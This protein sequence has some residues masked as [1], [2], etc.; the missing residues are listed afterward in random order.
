MPST[1]FPAPG[2]TN[3][4][5][6]LEPFAGF[7]GPIS[8]SGGTLNNLLVLS[9]DMTTLTVVGQQA[10][11]TP[12]TYSWVP[13]AGITSISAVVVG[14]GGGG[15]ANGSGGSAWNGS[16]GGGGGLAYANSIP[17]SSGTTYTVQVGAGGTA[18]NDG[19]IS[20][21]NSS[22]YLYANGGKKGV[23]GSTSNAVG[24]TTLT[25]TGAGSWVV[26]FGVTAVNVAVVGGGGG[27]GYFYGSGGGG[28]A[29]SYANNIPVTPN[30]TISYNVGSGGAVGLAGTT[31]WFNSSS[32]I[33]ANGGQPGIYG[34]GPNNATGQT[35]ITTAGAGS[36]AA[37]TGVT[38][39]NVV[40]LG[41]GGGGGGGNGGGGGGGALTYAN[42]VPVTPGTTYSYNVGSGGAVD[43]AGTTTWF[44]TSSYLYAGGGSAGASGADAVGESYAFGGGGSSGAPAGIGGGGF[45][46]P[47]A[48]TNSGL[49]YYTF[50]WVAPPGVTSVNVVCIGGGAGG[51]S[52]NGISVGGGGGGGGGLG[53]KNNIPVVPGTTYTVQVGSGGT[54]GG[55][56]GGD[57]WFINST[58]VKGG[59]GSSGNNGGSGSN[60][61][62][63]GSFVGDG[64]GTGY[65]GGHATGSLPGGGGGAGGYANISNGGIGGAGGQSAPCNQGNGGAGGGG[66]AVATGGGRTTG[67]S[68]GGNGIYGALDGGKFT[69]PQ[70]E[71]I[72]VTGASS[73]SSGGGGGG[74]ATGNGVAGGGSSTSGST[75]AAG[76]VAGYYGG[77]GGGQL[78]GGSSVAAANGAQGAMRIVWGSGR[79]FSASGSVVFATVVNGATLGTGGGG[80]AA[81]YGAN[82]GAGGSAASVAHAGGTGGTG[83]GSISVTTFTGGAGGGSAS[84]ASAYSAATSPGNGAGAGGSG[85]VSGFGGGGVGVSGQTSVD[86]T[87]SA[88]TAGSATTSGG[89]A[90]SASNGGSG[91]SSGTTTSGGT[92]GG[93]G[94]GTY[95]GGTGAIRI[96]WGTSRSFPSTNTID[97]STSAYNPTLNSGGGGGGAAGYAANGGAGGGASTVTYAGGTGGTGGGSVSGVVTYT[98]GAGG[99]SYAGDI[100]YNAAT[101]PGGG[102]GAGGAGG[103]VPYGGGGLGVLGQTTVNSTGQTTAAGT[104]TISGVSAVSAYNGGSGGIDGSTTSGGI[105]G[106]GGPGG[107]TGGAGGN[108]AI[109]IIW[110]TAYPRS[111]PS[112]STA[113]LTT[114]YSGYGGGG[115]GGAAGYANNGGVGSGVAS[116]TYSGG[117]GGTAG[118]SVAGVVAYSGGV[119]GAS[120]TGSTGGYTGATAPASAG[121]G[122]SGGVGAYGGGG[123]GNQVQSSTDS[124]G[125]ATSAGTNTNIGGT[126]SA[127]STGGSGGFSSLSSVG[128]YYGGG[129]GGASG[130]FAGSGGSGSVRLVW[131]T[132][133]AVV[134][135]YPTLSADLTGTVSVTWNGSGLT[136]T[137]DAYGV[138]TITSTT[139]SQYLYQQATVLPSTAYTFSFY[140]KPGTATDATYGVYDATNGNNIVAPTSYYNTMSRTST[141]T[142]FGTSATNT[143]TLAA[144][145]LD[146]YSASFGGTNFVYNSAVDARATGDFTLE[147]WFFFTGVGGQN[148]ILNIGNETTGRI[149]IYQTPT[150][151][152]LWYNIYGGS[153]VSLT[154]T[155][156]VNNTWNH[157]AIVRSGTSLTTY[158]NGVGGT[159]LTLSGTLGNAT[160]FYVMGDGNISASGAGLI[161]NMRLVLGSALY[162]ANFTPARSNLA[163]INGTKFLLF[164]GSTATKDDSNNNYTLSNFGSTVG[165]LYVPGPG[166]LYRSIPGTSGIPSN[167][168]VTGITNTTLTLSA[169]LTATIG[170]SVVFRDTA[171][172]R[173][174]STFT[175][176]ATCTSVRVY[177]LWTISSGFGTNYLMGI[178]LEQGSNATA[179]QITVNS[180]SAAQGIVPYSTTASIYTGKL[181]SAETVRADSSIRSVG[182]VSSRAALRL[183]P[184]SK[185][186]FGLTLG[187]SVAKLNS[188]P[189]NRYTWSIPDSVL[190]TNTN[191]LSDFPVTFYNKQV[192]VGNASA[193]NLTIYTASAANNNDGTATLRIPALTSNAITTNPN[194]SSTELV[195]ITDSV[196]GNQ[197]IATNFSTTVVPSTAGQQLYTAILSSGSLGTVVAPSPV[198]TSNGYGYG[199]TFVPPTGVTSISVVAVGGGGM[200]NP[201][202]NYTG[203]G[204]GG[205]AWVNNIPVVPGNS[206]TVVVGAGG[207]S[208]WNGGVSYFNNTSTVAGYGGASGTGTGFVAGG[209][210]TASISYGTYGGGS[211]GN[212]GTFT[213]VGGPYESG[214]G[215]AGGYAGSGGNGGGS[216]GSSTGTAATAGATNSGAGGGGGA[217]YDPSNA[218]SAA[219]GGGGGVGLLGKGTTGTAGANRQNGTGSGGGD[220]GV[221]GSGGANGTNGTNAVGGLGGSY[222]GGGGGSA[223]GQGIGSY[224][225]VRIIWPGSRDISNPAAGQSADVTA[226]TQYFLTTTV[227]LSTIISSLNLSSIYTAQLWDAQLAPSSRVKSTIAPTNARENLYYSNITNKRGNS[228]VPT[229]TWAN[230]RPDDA[231]VFDPSNLTKQI[232]KL[233]NPRPDDA[234]VFDPN[235]LT[236]LPISRYR[237]ANPRPDDATVFD[238]SNL[239]KQ[240]EKL[241][242]PDRRGTLYTPG[243]LGIFQLGDRYRLGLLPN[244][245]SFFTAS[246]YKYSS[247]QP[248]TS[249]GIPY[250]LS[251]FDSAFWN[252]NFQVNIGTSNPAKTNLFYIKSVSTIGNNV[253]LSFITSRNPIAGDFLGGEAVKLSDSTSGFSTVAGIIPLGASDITAL[254]LTANQIVLTPG[255]GV[256]TVPDNCYSIGVVCIGG[257]GSGYSIDNQGNGVGGGGGGGGLGW[258]N[259]TVAPGQVFTY[260]VGK[261]GGNSTAPFLIN[262]SYDGGDTNFGGVVYGRGGKGGG[263]YTGGAGG[264]YTG[265]GGGNGGPGGGG[266]S[267]ADT[268]GSGGG[269]AGG[270][271]GTGG[272][273]ASAG[274]SNGTT[275]YIAATGGTGGAGGGGGASTGIGFTT[276]GGA[277]GGG[278]GATGSGIGGSGIAG[279]SGDGS[280]LNTSVKQG[281]GG[282]GG[283][284]GASKNTVDSSQAGDLGQNGGNY[285]GGG[286]GGAVGSTTYEGAGEGGSGAIRI[287]WGIGR[288]YPNTLATDQSFTTPIGLNNETITIPSSFISNFASLNFNA[289]A[290]TSNWTLTAWAPSVQTSNQ[291]VIGSNS[292][293][294]SLPRVNLMFA[295]IAPGIRSARTL[296][297]ADSI[298]SNTLQSYNMS[299]QLEVIKN[300]T[301]NDAIVFDPNNLQKQLEVIKNPTATETRFFN[302]FGYKQYKITGNQAPGIPSLR[303]YYLPT[304]SSTK[305]PLSVKGGANLLSSS[306]RL[307]NIDPIYWYN[308]NTVNV[309]QSDTRIGRNTYYVSSSTDNG[310]NTTLTMTSYLAP[311]PPYQDYGFN[312]GGGY[313]EIIDANGNSVLAPV[314]SST[315][316]LSTSSVS[317][318]SVTVSPGTTTWTAPAGV[319]TVSIL[320][321]GA[322]GGGGTGGG[323]GGGGALAYAN[324]VPVVP[325][326]VYNI[327]V[328]AGGALNTD[329]TDTWFNNSSYLFAG[330]GKKGTSSTDLPVQGQT[331]ITATGTGSWVAPTGVRSISLV[332]IGAGGGGGASGNSGGGGG[333]ALTYAN[334]IPVVPGTTY[335]YQIG[336]G[337][338]AGSSGTATWFNTSSYFFAGGGSVGSI[339]TDAPVQGQA[340]ITATGLSSWVAPTG[341]S[342]INVVVLGGGGGGG[343][344]GSGSGGGGGGLAY[345]NNIPVTPGTTYSVQVGTGGAIGA[346]GGISWFNSS[347]YLYANGGSAGVLSTAAPVQGQTTITTTGTGSWVAPTGVNAISVV[348]IGAGGGGG[349]GGNGSGGGGGGLTYANNIPVVPG[350]T[351]NY[352]IGT[353]GAVDTGGTAT[354][355]NTS[356]YL[357]A[358]GGSAGSASSFAA[359]QGQATFTSLGFNAWT[360]PAGV[361][362]ISVV[363]LGGGGGGGKGGSGG[364]GGGL[365]YA[366]NVPVT[367]G[368]SYQI[369]VGA[370]GYG[371]APGQVATSGSSS[372][373]YFDYPTNSNYITATGGS[374][375]TDSSYI[376]VQGQ[377]T[378]TTTGTGSWVAPANVSS[379]SVLFFGGGGGG[380]VGGGGGGGGG[381]AYANNIPVSPGTTYS[382]RVGSGGAANANGTSS[383]FN[384]SSYLFAGGGLA[385]TQNLTNYAAQGQALAVYPNTT[386][387]TGMTYVSPGVFNWVAPQGVTSVSVVS[388]GGGGGGGLGGGSAGGGGGGALTYA[389]SVPVTPGT[390]YT[391]NVGAGGAAGSSGTSTWFNSSSYLYANGGGAGTYS[392]AKPVIDQVT[393]TTVG[394]T[395]WTVPDGVTSISIVLLGGGGGGGSGNGGG[396]GGGGLAYANNIPV[397]PGMSID[398]TVGDAGIADTNGGTSSIVFHD[399]TGGTI[400]ATGGT[401]G[402]VGTAS[403]GIG[404]AIFTVTGVYPAVLPN[405]TYHDSWTVPAGVTSVSALVIGAGGRGGS[406]G[407]Y[408]HGGGGGGGLVWGNNISVTPG[409]TMAVAAGRGGNY[410]GFGGET[411]VAS[412]TSYFNSVPIT[413][414]S[415][416]VSCYLWAYAGTDGLGGTSTYGSYIHGGGG[417]AAGYSANGGAGSS[418]SGGTISGAGGQGGSSGGSC[419]SGGFSGGRGGDSGAYITGV[420][421]TSTAAGNPGGGAGAGGAATR[422]SWTGGGVGIYGPSGYNING[423]P[424][425][426]WPGGETL[427][428]LVGG[429]TNGGSGGY[430]GTKSAN[431]IGNA[432]YRD[433]NGQFGAGAGGGGTNYGGGVVRIIWGPG[434][435]FPSTLVDSNLAD[436][437]VYYPSGGGGGAAG[438]S[439][440]GGNGGS[441]TA[442][443][444]FAGGT[445]GAG[446]TGVVRGITLVSRSG[447]NGGASY[448]GNSAF[449]AATLGSGGAGAGGSG[450]LNSVGGGGIAYTGQ[451]SLNSTGQTTVAGTATAI[452]ANAAIVNNG[453]SGGNNG[454]VGQGGSFGSGGSGS[455][456]Y[457]GPGFVRIIYSN[458]YNKARSY[459][460]TLTAD[461][462]NTAVGTPFGAGGGGGAAGYAANGGTGGSATATGGI[463]YSGGTGGTG[464]G[465][466]SVTTFTGGTGGAGYSTYS[467]FSAGTNPGGGAG[468]GG[469]GGRGA[470]G[471]GG[472]GVTNQSSLNS[473]GSTTAGGAA[474][475]YATG[476]VGI[477]ATANNGGSG[478]TNG[479]TST[480]GGNGAGGPAGGAG[481]AGALRIIWSNTQTRAYPNTLAVDQAVATGYGTY[482]VGG[483]G[484]AAGY[485][486]NG[487]A[488]GSA[489]N[490]A[491]YPGGLGGV[492]GGSVAGVSGYT[493]GLGGAA[494]SGYSAFTAP[495]IPTYTGDTTFL[496]GQTMTYSFSNADPY[497]AYRNY[498]GSGGSGASGADVTVTFKGVGLT[499]YH[500][501]TATG[502]TGGAGGG[503]SISNSNGY[504]FGVNGGYGGSGGSSTG[505]AGGSLGG[506]IGPDGGTSYPVGARPT[507]VNGLLTAVQN[508]GVTLTTFAVGGVNQSDGTFAGAGGGSG[509]SLSYTA[510]PGSGGR[511]AVSGRLPARR[512]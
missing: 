188:L 407:I 144:P 404:E 485:A 61:G 458:V 186:A 258:K 183:V 139:N 316:G 168:A 495:S 234:Y 413:T 306:Y 79:S 20:W 281:G 207:G 439:G 377:T 193:K 175:T 95:G 136:A 467:A 74:G 152:A 459:P 172:T 414:T 173:I 434:R 118:G 251:D 443:A 463:A 219:G 363:L 163:A 181:K 202:S 191:K 127:S 42:S 247:S 291:V 81:G 99:G 509:G 305:V 308:N 436:S 14:G 420:M 341:V 449:S 391:V 367:P 93:G 148:T 94:P 462:D 279:T 89:T 332:G 452:N 466:I 395:N 220:G 66:G 174:I 185:Y 12:G 22:T 254:T 415:Q 56:A 197:I 464:G 270:Y 311:A 437:P 21:F 382:Y 359:T 114:L 88:T 312:V 264:T 419:R 35:T 90:T 130:S 228:I 50:N 486:A 85:G 384:T 141:I 235:K 77:G 54:G 31:S 164:K 39:I 480:G 225:A 368:Q 243:K 158:V 43:T 375:G 57:T 474:V 208:S 321:V 284:G 288:S 386:S 10:Y 266:Y 273:G 432:A 151:G 369:N 465:S 58:T 489:V 156:A 149:V 345:A 361:T 283:G 289:V 352:Q 313:V 477:G 210:Y 324:A 25:T 327:Q 385:G 200:G 112:T 231:T 104:S 124:S 400:S 215:G 303:A 117:V 347:S 165:S 349:S 52:N 444:S 319:F 146:G 373:M 402:T 110:P 460:T 440:N 388:V 293:S 370:G 140:A 397:T 433:T 406:S 227:S 86:S 15:G 304:I 378:L 403:G 358:N 476:V 326:T 87:G 392:T 189:I 133:N 53:W 296:S 295:N 446:S 113:D 330:G 196:T 494:Y 426:A 65:R 67:G 499:A 472:V 155:F 428:T 135:T 154:S 218:G 199:Y 170:G 271:S 162:T 244:Y 13:P 282:S 76:S 455:G 157:I 71:G 393:F 423:S 167:T 343:A 484:A 63:G 356:S 317:M 68:G 381:L 230:P 470:Y 362:S 51:G 111:F 335:N 401:A 412:G 249:Y 36:W 178:Q 261:G 2:F 125:A 11:S 336:T 322:G 500:G 179:Y 209:T 302:T 248:E 190:S 83:G 448:N 340:T 8:F 507:D 333:G 180:S 145:F 236:T 410:N 102:A 416:T 122:G 309:G 481:G 482:G 425:D 123:V 129:G 250:K 224:G 366:N 198:L 171:W 91:G 292:Y 217:G 62:A 328:G 195:L 450:G 502:G 286:G 487:G 272:T 492:G 438:Y 348:A 435:A 161:S 108:G 69:C 30:T 431:P 143:I 408:G 256:W 257:G 278:V 506:S 246:R 310:T 97:Q 203:G 205:L 49:G 365:I 353:G 255:T 399:V 128:G 299:K 315:G 194:I 510:L 238:P 287:I 70:N 7:N 253:L 206:Y 262:T 213:G 364:G 222:G 41:G 212:S 396:G 55:G 274:S 78:I 126:A 223:S 17:V 488:G 275:V 150:T 159:P 350:T 34:D 390:T 121:A 471:G 9:E 298:S 46:A 33:Y 371:G 387:G 28:G 427:S 82:G 5:Q 232:E 372:T 100:G 19:G 142:A 176:P 233:T 447:G 4:T 301:Y 27:G 260:T 216:S 116:G 418:V 40:L 214:G 360:A 493:G 430:D 276:G 331:V 84:A 106:A 491:T 192:T 229:Y 323:G 37:P 357:Y 409:T 252:Y 475:T 38:N 294:R 263:Y 376:P 277:G 411:I 75:N 134:R 380:G 320:A 337:G 72:T 131:G 334:N 461:Q 26:P 490:G 473:A 98:G 24:Q 221:G 166:T 453:G 342:N 160:G 267:F 187:N 226:T 182:K 138:N 204:G 503:Y 184:L 421:T 394:T 325:G 504:S 92:Y 497:T 60:G 290:K 451:T 389:N 338:V 314:L 422:V 153:A 457:G 241:T 237:F 101:N 73:V 47:T 1:N 115:G 105:Y 454:V 405:I 259:I 307:D 211:G 417:G 383:W 469:A 265:D 456:G 374:A 511:A 479:D 201:G 355:F 478:G 103:R 442:G 132:V 107:G 109:R 505:G 398:V 441:A 351:Y 268:L 354:W 119:G 300:P 245:T 45:I 269:G 379:V 6:F 496:G 242:T 318:S 48:G 239:T 177:P 16:G 44:N 424:T 339:S 508:A 280:Y 240:I 18:D 285:G 445:G 96:I 80:G 297:A 147:G 468:A 23:G 329:G 344:S 346:A 29:L 501:V 498:Y 483:G 169:N 3:S 120:S 32:Y 512:L 59:G 137:K 429:A 64:G